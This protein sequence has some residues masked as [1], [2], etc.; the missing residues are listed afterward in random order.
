MYDE[1]QN[2]DD[3]TDKLHKPSKSEVLGFESEKKSVQWI[4]KGRG[5]MRGNGSHKR[6]KEGPPSSFLHLMLIQQHSTQT[7]FCSLTP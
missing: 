6:L 4:C 7:Q 1:L 5:N 2:R 3:T